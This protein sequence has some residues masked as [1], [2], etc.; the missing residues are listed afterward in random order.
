MVLHR[1]SDIFRIPKKIRP[2]FKRAILI[3]LSFIIIYFLL[4]DHPKVKLKAVSHLM[5]PI[6]YLIVYQ[7][8]EEPFN[9]KRF[10]ELIEFYKSFISYDSNAWDA[11]SLLAYCYYHIG[12]VE[13][14]VQSY[15]QASKM[16]PDFF[17]NYYNLGVIYF[18]QRQYLK[19]SQYFKKAIDSSPNKTIYEFEKSVLYSYV[20]DKDRFGREYR[21]MEVYADF[22]KV[23]LN[24]Q[25]GFVKSYEFMIKSYFE[26]GDYEKALLAASRGIKSGLADKSFLYYYAGMASFK[27]GEFER[28][29]EFF[30]GGLDLS[31]EQSAF[32]QN[33]GLSYQLLNR[34]EAAQE[35][36][37]RSDLFESG[38]KDQPVGSGKMALRLF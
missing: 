38:G 32:W 13:K 7:N 31:K 26:A 1:L 33:I 9:E 3:P 29:I 8:D 12:D 20:A 4:V 15:L 14:S 27:L 35:A 36:F 25:Q 23:E 10:K 19:A 21:W 2:F 34:E 28:A 5:I 16:M 30:M 22:E 37:D 18:K 17:W 11:H 6:D 24:L